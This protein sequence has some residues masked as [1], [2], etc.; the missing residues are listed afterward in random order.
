MTKK[1]LL[2]VMSLPLI[3]MISL[4]STADA[5]SLGISIPVDRIE[6]VEE[7][8]VYLDLDIKEKYKIDYTVYPTNAKNQE[9]SLSTEQVG[10]QRL[11]E[12]DFEDGYLIPK[13]I[14]MA[15]VYLTTIDGGFK[16]SFI[17]QID[18]NML[19]EVE[20]EISQT[21]MY[22]GNKAYITTAFIPANAS[23]QVVAYK[24][25]DT[26]V[27]TV[28]KTGEVLGVGKG[29]ATITVYSIDDESI[30]DTVT[31]N[32]F[33]TDIMDISTDSIITWNS[34]GTFNLSLDTEEE[35]ELSYQ[36]LDYALNPVNTSDITVT[37]GEESSNG[38]VVAT[39]EFNDSFIGKYTIEVTIKTKLGHKL[40]KQV[41]I[42]KVSQVNASFVYDKAPA[43]TMGSMN[44]LNFMITPNTDDVTY[45][46]EA[47]NDNVS[48]IEQNGLII[49]NALYPGETLVTVKV[50]V[51]GI[52]EPVVAS[53]NVIV[54]PKT[55]NIN[56]LGTSYGIEQTW[57]IGGK[58]YNDVNTLIS[59]NSNL[60]ISFGKET[61]SLNISD[62]VQYISY[63]AVDKDGNN[64]IGNNLIT[65]TKDT[66]GNAVFTIGESIKGTINF[67]AVFKIGEAV[68]K[69]EAVAI[70]CVGSA[71]NVDCYEELLLATK[72]NKE[73]VLKNDITDFGKFRDGSDMKIE[74]TYVEIPTTYDWTYYK[75]IGYT[76]APTVKVLIQIKNNIYGN[77]HVINAHNLAYGLDSSDKLLDSAL[78]Q[79]PLNFVAVTDSGSSSISVK[80]QDN[81]SFAL[82][83]NV[84]VSNT[85]LRACDLKADGN[86]S[87]DLTDL[88]YTGTVV[89]VLGDNVNLL[90]SRVTNGRTGIRVFGDVNDANKEIHFNISNCII[91]GARE[92]LIRMGSNAF[93]DGNLD[94]P[95]PTLPNNTIKNFPVQPTYN[96]MSAD[97][98]AE[99][100][101]KYI[102]TFV[103]V[104]NSVFKDCGIFSIGIDSHFAGPLL[105]DGASDKILG[106]RFKEILGDHWHDLAKT[107]YGAKLTFD[108]DVRIFDWKKLSMVDSSTLITVVKG[109]QLFEK[110]DFNL[111][112]MVKTIAS[113]TKEG[114][115]ELKFA[116]IVYSNPNYENGE[117]YVH[118]GITI[119]GGGKNYGVFETLSHKPLAVLNNYTIGLADCDK[120]YL[121]AAA[122]SEKF[123]F[124]MHDATNTAFTPKVQN[125]YLSTENGYKN[126]YEK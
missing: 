82:Y 30:Y 43:F 12:V 39:Y 34:T 29:T 83:E 70:E 105:A 75:N 100:E 119:F 116:N 14:G 111:Q 4:F 40:S 41:L 67:R 123:Y 71:I 114:T 69:S 26:N 63:E 21:E 58:E 91:S 19:Q 72:S 60:T 77:G 90:Y 59:T 47:N 98:K 31:V 79:G 112:E 27:A 102:K 6:I 38:N 92:F 5:V 22:V 62:L 28:S 107:S 2:L 76:S 45:E 61:N 17:V 68:L 20:C 108:G 10:D 24:S 16:D 44:V 52:T 74:D 36:V 120:G 8:I 42:E 23:N 73:V 117:V 78:F 55:L 95:A 125:E 115:D 48:V 93:V 9:V 1:I 89:E 84:T 126:V 54:L 101:D 35:Y 113:I 66:N 96:S 86:G 7:N 104:K 110:M 85:E 49:L 15:K 103:Y 65:I 94:N 88:D 11:C 46:V 99:Y 25:S 122:G 80:A 56:E 64:A 81:I 50:F 51:P 13:S 97:K 3:L 124:L 121:E 106:G 53:Q 118:G 18:S 57:T 87:Y 33:N 32:I 109:N 37:F